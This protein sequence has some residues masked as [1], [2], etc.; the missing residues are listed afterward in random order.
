MVEKQY[1]RHRHRHNNT[2]D[3]MERKHYDIV[4]LGAG[5]AGATTALCL[6]A[7]KLSVLV[8]E[9]KRHPRWAVGESTVPQT[10]H[11]FRCLARDNN[12]PELANVSSYLGMK[13][14]NLRT[15][16]KEAFW[17]GY[18]KPGEKLLLQ[19]EVVGL[20]PLPPLGPDSHMLRAGFV[21]LLPTRT[22][23][24]RSK[25]YF[26]RT[27]LDDYLT[28]LLPKYG[29]S[30]LDN[31]NPKEVDITPEGVRLTL[32]CR[33]SNDESASVTLRQCTARFVVDATGH[34]CYLGRKF[35][36]HHHE[37]QLIHRSRTIYSHFETPPGWSLEKIL[38]Q[39][40]YMHSTRDGGTIHHAFEGGKNNQ[41]I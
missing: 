40:P 33:E 34:N 11:D 30:Y 26:D 14:A 12:V 29:V 5:I 24:A 38:E 31:T 9:R 36:L 23:L 27:D 18:H 32:E 15:Y 22:T 2:T 6:G 7:Q 21:F 41:W 39:N 25:P 37:P 13:N 4:V 28:S 35:N 19:N 3:H 20:T 16:P 10:T 8:V 1:N 17:F